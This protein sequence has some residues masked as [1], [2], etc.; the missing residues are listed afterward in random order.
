M[1]VTDAVWVVGR[2][3]IAPVAG[4]SAGCASMGRNGCRARVES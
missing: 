4:C 3:T 1:N 2:L